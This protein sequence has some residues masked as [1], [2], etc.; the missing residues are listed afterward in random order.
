MS[1]TKNQVAVVNAVV[2]L[3]CVGYFAWR[4]SSGREPVKPAAP[5]D[6]APPPIDAQLPPAHGWTLYDV[7]ARQLVEDY[8]ANEVAADT[9]YLRTP[10]LVRGIVDHVSHEGDGALLVF[11]VFGGRAHV[12]AHLVDLAGVD[13]VKARQEAAVRC[14]GDGQFDGPQLKNCALE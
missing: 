8:A 6:A 13:A 2:V 3:G 7:T 11:L 5:A 14:F 9:K 12:T 1:L 10:I 4:W